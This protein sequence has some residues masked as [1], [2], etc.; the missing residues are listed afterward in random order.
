MAVAPRD[1]EITREEVYSWL[2][3]YDGQVR[4]TKKLHDYLEA[5]IQ[6]K[7]LPDEMVDVS[8]RDDFVG[9][10]VHVVDTILEDLPSYGYGP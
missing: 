8:Q 4:P 5:K 6:A 3:E 7:N 2:Q 1:I 9:D 10:E